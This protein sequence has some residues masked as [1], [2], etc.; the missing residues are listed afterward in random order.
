MMEEGL[1]PWGEEPLQMC[2]GQ[3]KHVCAYA[4]GARGLR[5]PG[6][7]VQGSRAGLPLPHP[8]D[9][10]GHCS[11]GT[12]VELWAAISLSLSLFFLKIIYIS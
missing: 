4:T 1:K 5:H 8:H 11:A 3:V 12:S 10:W 2:S 7:L 9:P 6:K